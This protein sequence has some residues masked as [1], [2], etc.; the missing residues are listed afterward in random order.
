[1]NEITTVTTTGLTLTASLS[2]DGVIVQSGI[3]MQETTTNGVYVGSMPSVS[4]GNYIVLVF[5]LGI[6]I[7]SGVIYWDGAREITPLL[8]SEIHKIQGLDVLNPLTTTQNSM[9]SGDVAI[10]ITGNGE[11]L[12][13]FTRT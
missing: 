13:I 8:Y 12:S 9:N 10:A 2:L 11:T 1:M 4:K 3:T 6:V 5:S 7:E